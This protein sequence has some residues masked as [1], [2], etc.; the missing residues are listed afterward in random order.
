MPEGIPNDKV[1]RVA[2]HQMVLPTTNR[3]E[4]TTVLNSL[5][6]VDVMDAGNLAHTLNDIF[7]VL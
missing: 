4:P 5:Q 1:T 6:S 2:V 7:Q 3:Q